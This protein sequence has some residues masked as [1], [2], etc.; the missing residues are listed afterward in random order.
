MRSSKNNITVP[1]GQSVM[2]PCRVDCGPLERRTPV[3][4]EPAMDPSWS[5]D[6]EVSEQLLTLPRAV[7]NPTKHDIVF[8][9]RTPL[10][11]LQLIASVT[12]LEVV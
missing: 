3:L 10:G 6:L 5:A 4:F 7:Y 2:V 11:N 9:R 8:G 12:P 1:Q